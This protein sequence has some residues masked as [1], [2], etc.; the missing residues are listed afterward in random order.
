MLKNIGM[1]VM[2]LIVVCGLTFG[3]AGNW[4][5]TDIERTAPYKAVLN[6]VPDLTPDQYATASVRVVQ[7]LNGDMSADRMLELSADDPLI[8]R[9]SIAIVDAL[10]AEKTKQLKAKPS[11]PSKVV[12]VQTSV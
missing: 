1:S 11:L 7:V 2:A 9:A 5:L 10:L 12:T 8:T 3:E 6:T 4:R